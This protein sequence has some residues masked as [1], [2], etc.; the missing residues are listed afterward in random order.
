MSQAQKFYLVRDYS[1]TPGSVSILKAA[2]DPEQFKFL[3]M[4]PPEEE[5]EEW[6]PIQMYDF[7]V[8]HYNL[9]ENK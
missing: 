4:Y 7:Y 8:K 6:V 3:R 1:S 2:P 9:G 5:L